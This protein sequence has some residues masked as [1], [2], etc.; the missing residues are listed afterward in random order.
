MPAMDVIDSHAL[1]HLKAQRSPPIP[2][3]SPACQPVHDADMV[4][5]GPELCPKLDHEAIKEKAKKRKKNKKKGMLPAAP[6]V[7]I[8]KG[9]QTPVTSG[10]EESDI[11]VIGTPMLKAVNSP[12]MGGISALKSR[13]DA[14][15][16][17]CE[18][19]R[20][21]LARVLSNPN[22]YESTASQSSKGSEGDK[23]EME[24]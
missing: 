12:A 18:D 1:P 8:I 15:S 19:R 4:E 6:A 22:G 2:I 14:L 10:G 11:S 17:D 13:L 24:T 5:T 23:T 9:F 21:N 7:N 3:A 20:P 16:L